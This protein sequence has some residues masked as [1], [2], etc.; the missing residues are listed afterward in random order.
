MIDKLIENPLIK[1][2]FLKK[3]KELQ[4]AHGMTAV[5]IRFVGEEIE[6]EVYTEPVR[7]MKESDYQQ[8][9]QALTDHGTNT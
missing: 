5:A 3:L 9:I 1:K 2:M 4:K 6:F 8:T 7:M